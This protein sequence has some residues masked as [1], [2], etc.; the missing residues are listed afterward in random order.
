MTWHNTKIGLLDGICSMCFGMDVQTFKRFLYLIVSYNQM[1]LEKKPITGFFAK[2]WTPLA[3]FSYFNHGYDNKFLQIGYS[4]TYLGWICVWIKMTIRVGSLLEQLRGLKYK[5]ERSQPKVKMKKYIKPRYPLYKRN[6][7]RKITRLKRKREQEKQNKYWGSLPEKHIPINKILH[8]IGDQVAN[9]WDEA[10]TANPYLLD[11]AIQ[12]DLFNFTTTTKVKEEFLFTVGDTVLDLI[13]IT[14]TGRMFRFQ[15][16]YWTDN[17]QGNRIIFDSGAS[18]TIT[19]SL[20]DFISINKS[21]TAIDNVSLQGLTAK[22]AVK[23]VDTIRL[24]VYTDGGFPRFIETEAYWVPE[25]KTRLLSIT[26]YAKSVRGGCYF[27]CDENGCHFQFPNKSG[28][29]GE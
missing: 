18:V 28:G 12:N 27:R 17:S 5:K 4:M 23:A 10:C 20:E 8:I 16:A 26:N 1:D 9:R 13:K 14:E 2:I 29:G 24:L 11:L 21:T 15:T 7:H 3:M 25:A 19:P 6:Y 22:A